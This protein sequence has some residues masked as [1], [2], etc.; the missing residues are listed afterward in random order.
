TIELVKKRINKHVKDDRRQ[1]RSLRQTTV[2]RKT[3]RERSI[4]NKPE[5]SIGKHQRPNQ[6]KK[7]NR[8]PSTAKTGHDTMTRGDV[9]CRSKVEKHR[10]TNSL[11]RKSMVTDRSLSQ[12]RISL[13]KTSLRR[14]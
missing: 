7:K 8:H 9:I 4:D 1:R 14:M 6:M 11:S 5:R 12:R 10:I 13:S 3:I 2:T